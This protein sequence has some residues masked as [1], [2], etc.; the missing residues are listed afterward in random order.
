MQSSP[1]AFAIGIC[2]GSS[3]NMSTEV[4]NANLGR[5]IEAEHGTIEG[6]WQTIDPAD[7]GEG[8]IQSLWKEAHKK[9]E[10]KTPQGAPKNRVKNRYAPS[11]LII[12]VSE[13]K[14]KKIL[15]RTM[16][17]RFGSGRTTKDWAIWS[18][19]SMM[20]FIPFLLPT[21]S[22]RSLSKVTSTIKHHIYSKATETT[23]DLEVVD[24]FNT[25]DYLEGKTMQ[26]AILET[27]SGKLPG[28]PVFKNITR[29]WSR[30]YLETN[31]QITSYATLTE[32]AD[33]AAQGL[34][35]S[36]QE[37]YGNDALLH[38]PEGS[39]LESYS[40]QNRKEIEA[41]DPET[42]KL[43]EDL[44]EH[45]VGNILAPE[46]VSI[47]E[48]EA[49]GLTT[50]GTST[51]QFSEEDKMAASDKETSKLQESETEEAD[52]KHI[53]DNNNVDNNS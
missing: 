42:I 18:D 41:E 48:L 16:T 52:C 44:D 39:L 17:K 2:Q 37:K 32:E 40:H 26:Q 24:L 36:I 27:E 13:M 7:L 14:Y 11:G 6:S 25:K 51:I 1:T 30:N 53:R 3:P 33:A 10:E 38:F 22:A 12:Y 23:R 4:I 46:Y 45:T 50:D 49:G 47:L 35:S 34:M 43:L 31:Y 9:A 8:I 15:K 21:S 20:R 5:E 28:M 29:K 19:G